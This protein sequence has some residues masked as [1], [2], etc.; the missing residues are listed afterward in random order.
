MK[1]PLTAALIIANALSASAVDF[2]KEVKPIFNQKCYACHAVSKGKTKG[3]LALDTAERLAEVIK[4]GGQIIPGDPAKSSLLTSCKLPDDDDDSMP[5]KGKNR[6]TP[7]ELITLETWIKE[8]A[9]M[10]GGAAPPVAAAPPAAAPTTGGTQS[11][12]S[13]DGKA[14]QATFMGLQGDGVLLKMAGNG[15]TFLVPLARLSADSQ[16]QAKAAK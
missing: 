11:W 6:L 10:T 8:G 15:E 7:A 3:D 2:T 12:T 4:P 1:S 5:P 13:N 14:I 16:A 9:S